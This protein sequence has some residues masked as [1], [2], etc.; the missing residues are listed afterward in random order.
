MHENSFRRG[1]RF[2]G[3][4][5]RASSSSRTGRSSTATSSATG[6]WRAVRRSYGDSSASGSS[7]V[8]AA[9]RRCSRSAA[10]IN[11]RSWP[12]TCAEAIT[13]APAPPTNGGTWPAT[14]T[15]T[16][17]VAAIGSDAK[18]LVFSDDIPWCRE[19]LGIED[20][21]YID[22]DAYTSLCMMTGCD[23]NVIANS[24][25]S[26]WGAY[27]NRHADVYA[28]SRGTAPRIARRTT[29]RTTS[30]RRAGARSRC[31]PEPEPPGDKL[32]AIPAKARRSAGRCQIVDRY[33][34]FPHPTG[35]GP[36]SRERGRVNRRSRARQNDDPAPTDRHLPVEVHDL[37]VWHAPAL[38]PHVLGHHPRAPRSPPRPCRSAGT[39]CGPARNR[40]RCHKV[41]GEH[42]ARRGGRRLRQAASRHRR[43]RAGPGPDLPQ[44]IHSSRP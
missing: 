21:H 38:D 41:S 20:A 28:P 31:T 1:E 2:G 15:T 39:G 19:S 8:R 30:C 32:S 18:Y 25:F 42:Q 5:I 43:H 34:R 24:T 9:R 11:G 44:R 17:V 23:I 35:P 7:T 4:T 36:Q 37:Q 40:S 27:L 3:T 29:S 12:S 6:T 14:A 10:C 16:W 26:W 33:G 13:S 22:L